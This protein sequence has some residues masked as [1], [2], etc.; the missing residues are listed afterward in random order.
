MMQIEIGL[1]PPATPGP[2]QAEPSA[3]TEA[4]WA[5]VEPADLAAP[6]S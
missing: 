4:P 2:A 3:P 6:A 5:L 1:L